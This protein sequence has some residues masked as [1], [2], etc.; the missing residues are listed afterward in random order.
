MT[1]IPVLRRQRWEDLC[2]FKVS[3]V[4][5]TSSRIARDTHRNPVLKNT[6]NKNK[7]TKK[8]FFF[9][10]TYHKNVWKKMRFEKKAGFLY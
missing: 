6:N 9:S 7:Q 4:F 1:L 5:S 2:E 3:L 8:N 10:Q